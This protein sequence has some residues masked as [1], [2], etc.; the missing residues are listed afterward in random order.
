MMLLIS[1]AFPRF[2]IKRLIL[3]L[4]FVK[5]EYKLQLQTETANSRLALFC[6]LIRP[7]AIESEQ[8]KEIYLQLFYCCSKMLYAEI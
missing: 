2:C 5:Q 7:Y 1:I 3:W 6:L 8:D 4:V